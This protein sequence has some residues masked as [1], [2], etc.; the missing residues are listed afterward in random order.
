MALGVV[1]AQ[2]RCVLKA[3]TGNDVPGLNIPQCEK[4]HRAGDGALVGNLA[5][6]GSSGTLVPKYAG[7]HTQVNI[8][9]TAG[10]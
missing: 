8:R 1:G 3:P 10:V 2:Q 5:D 9:P 6:M 4:D 7:Q